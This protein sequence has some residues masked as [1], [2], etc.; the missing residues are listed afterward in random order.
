MS[1]NSPFTFEITE[2]FKR[3]KTIEDIVGLNDFEVGDISDKI[4]SLEQSLQIISNNYV[5]RTYV[6][7]KLLEKVDKLGGSLLGNLELL[8]T[9]TNS[10]HLVTKEYIDNIIFDINTINA[11]LNTLAT[12][13]YVDDTKLSKYGGVL[14]GELILANIATQPLHPVAKQQLDDSLSNLVETG[15]LDW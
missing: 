3:L 15:N 9:P 11:Y 1:Q 12:K 7:N 6:D 2:L 5:S 14:L 13:Q 10:N 4:K 8:V